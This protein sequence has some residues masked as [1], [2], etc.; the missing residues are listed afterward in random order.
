DR[1]R[2][3]EAA[4]LGDV[5]WIEPSP[6]DSMLNDQAQWVVQGNVPN[7]RPVWDHGLRGQGQLVML[8]DGGLRA[9][10]EMFND[11]TVTI[12][13][14]GDYP[15]HRKIIAYKPGSDDPHVAFGDH[16]ENSYHGT[17]TGGTVAGSPGPYSTAP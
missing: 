15:T 14:W 2:L 8:A 1:S 7:S 4:A 6:R 12:P 3:A 17:H 10:H 9:N 13:G 11:S 16:V 5:A